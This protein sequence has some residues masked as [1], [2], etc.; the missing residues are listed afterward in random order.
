[1]NLSLLLCPLYVVVYY[2][3]TPCVSLL[4][5]MWER[6][7]D[8]AREKARQKKLVRLKEENTK[9]QEE[10]EKEAADLKKREEE[11]ASGGT[12]GN[13]AIREEEEVRRKRKGRHQQ[14]LEEWDDLA[15]EERLYK[16]FRKKKLTQEEYDLEL[17]GGGGEEDID[18]KYNHQDHVCQATENTHGD[19]DRTNKSGGAATRGGRKWKGSTGS[20]VGPKGETCVGRGRGRG[21][22]R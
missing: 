12:V 7:T 8:K 5:P 13:R 15:K 17:R 22:G 2:E 19:A 11:V 9:R 20:G 10:E 1:M 6:F 14:I 4:T 18:G 3:L 21:Q 16:K